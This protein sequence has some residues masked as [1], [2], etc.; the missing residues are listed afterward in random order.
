MP[1][2]YD[3]LNTLV[4]YCLSVQQG[5]RV[6]IESCPLTAP[7]IEAVYQEIIRAGASPIVL[8]SL[9][10]LDEILLRDG[11][12]EQICQSTRLQEVIAEEV[13]ALLVIRAEENSSGLNAVNPARILLRREA[14]D[15]IY[16]RRKQARW[17]LTRYPTN[18]LAQ[19]ANMSLN[20]LEEFAFDACFLNDHNPIQCWQKLGTEQQRLIDWLAGRKQVHILSG[21]TDLTLSIEGRRFVNGDGRRNFPSGEFYTS[22]LDQ[23][24]TGIIHFDI[25]SLV[26]GHLVEGIRLVF[27]RG[28]VIEASATPGQ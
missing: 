24:T 15:N 17:T 1:V 10:R 26:Y 11:N 16:A 12:N 5:E 21:G 8:L 25:P 3:G 4:R 27:Q 2:L 7:L 9:E 23:S 20:D 19:N 18:A 14:T 13:D 22:P 6:G 28:R